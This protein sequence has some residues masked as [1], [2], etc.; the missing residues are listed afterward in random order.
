MAT[1]IGGIINLAIGAIV[2]ATVFIATVQNT[3]TSNWSAGEVAMWG[4]LT[5][6]GI[7]GLLFGTLQVF[8]LA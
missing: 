6:V 4:A 8:G 1:F 5:I 3:N 7:A 2:L